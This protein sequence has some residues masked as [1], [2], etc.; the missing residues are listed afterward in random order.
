[1]TSGRI[2]AAPTARAIK[3][4]VA[5]RMTAWQVS[6]S[7]WRTPAPAAS[8]AERPRVF[9]AA[10]SSSSSQVTSPVPPT[11]R[12]SRAILLARLAELQL[13]V[14]H[15]DQAVN[16][17]HHFLDELPTLSCGRA[18]TAL[19]TMRASLRSH[20]RTPS[21]AN[22]L[23]RATTLTTATTRPAQGSKPAS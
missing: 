15:L 8:E 6:V 4:T 19:K 2:V 20:A 3:V 16:T 23:H 13:R 18:T 22:L 11:E 21:A 5:S 1:M 9:T 17:W 12:R 7:C 10:I 14:G